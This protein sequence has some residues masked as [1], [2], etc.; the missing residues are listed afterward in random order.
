[1][2]FAN[3]SHLSCHFNIIVYERFPWPTQYFIILIMKQTT[4]R[5]IKNSKLFTNYKR[6]TSK[7]L[8]KQNFV[9]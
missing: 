4:F 5:A 1:M 8:S 3:H 2:G 6:L 9:D 7:L